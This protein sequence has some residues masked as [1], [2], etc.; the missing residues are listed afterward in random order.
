ML[1]IDILDTI[2]VFKVQAEFLTPITKPIYASYFV[3]GVLFGF[4]HGAG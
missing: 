3:S 1:K 4:I 2:F